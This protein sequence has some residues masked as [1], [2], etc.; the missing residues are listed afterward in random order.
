M[1]QNPSQY[2]PQGFMPQFTGL[3]ATGFPQAGPGLFAQPSLYGINGQA[4]SPFATQQYPYAGQTGQMSAWQQNPLLQSP[5][6]QGP[7][8]QSHLQT[9]IVQ[10]LAYLAQQMLTQGAVTQQ[11]GIALHQLC[12]QLVQNLQAS[13]SGT[14]AVGQPFGQPLGFGQPFGTA[15]PFA[16]T[17]PF[18][19][20]GQ[21]FWQ[22]FASST[23]GYGGIGV[24]GAFSPQSGLGWGAGRPPTI[25]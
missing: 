7:F 10:G 18:G 20:A 25:Q 6:A 5:F 12:Q 16:G 22:P 3:Q 23:Q 17:Q 21:S 19:A 2:S 1:L 15:S 11:T 4:Q 14:V 8:M 24:Q 13:Q 9:Q